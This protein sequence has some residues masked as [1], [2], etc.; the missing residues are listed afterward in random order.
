MVC[1]T[2]INVY[3]WD[4]QSAVRS[5]TFLHWLT[6]SFKYGLNT[7]NRYLDDFIFV[8]EGDTGNFQAYTLF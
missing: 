1:F 4:V 6:L 2:E 8:D 3:Q 5:A 7:L